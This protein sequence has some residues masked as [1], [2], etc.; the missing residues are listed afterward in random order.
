MDKKTER[1]IL[2]VL[3]KGTLKYFGRTQALKKARKRFKE[4]KLKDGSPKWKLHWQCN[5][6]KKWYRDESDVEVDH[7]EEVGSYNGDIHEYAERMYNFG[8]NAQVL[9]LRCHRYKTNANATVRYKR[10]KK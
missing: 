1:F 9:C 10:K 4:G 5:K 8:D 6:C 2:N 3:R 7:I